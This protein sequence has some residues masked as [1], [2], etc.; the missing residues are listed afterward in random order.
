MT[1]RIALLILTIALALTGCGKKSSKTEASAPLTV[2]EWKCM[3]VDQKYLPETLERLK[4]GDPNLN[5]PEGWEE[6]QRTVVAP[7]RKQDFPNGKNKP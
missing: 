4:A 2:A 1:A 3:P 6:F 7:S 5:T